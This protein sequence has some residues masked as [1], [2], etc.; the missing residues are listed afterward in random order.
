MFSSQHLY[1]KF[2]GD[3]AE[4]HRFIDELF[5]HRVRNTFSTIPFYREHLAA[6]GLTPDDFRGISDLPK[7]PV[8]DRFT[9]QS[10]DAEMFVSAAALAAGLPTPAYTS[11]TSGEPVKLYAS[12]DFYIASFH[13]MQLAYGGSAPFTASCLSEVDK[14]LPE[15][16]GCQVHFIARSNSVSQLYDRLREI[17][18]QVALL[19][20]RRWRKLVEQY[21]HGLAGLNLVVAG[22][23]GAA[24]T[25][26]ERAY[27]S[28]FVGCPVVDM[29]GATELGG[30]V[31]ECP[32]GREHVLAH[33]NY[34]EILD[35]D[36]RPTAPGEPGHLVW[37]AL[38][39]SIMP[40]IRYR[41][42]DTG[43]F[44]VDQEC[45]CDWNGPVVQGIGGKTREKIVFAGGMTVSAY[46]LNVAVHRTPG[47]PLF[48]D[49]RFRQEE[50][51]LISLS[52]VRSRF[53]G[54]EEF[55]G[56]LARIDRLLGG[57]IRIE[58]TWVDEIDQP[59][60]KPIHFVPLG[61]SPRGAAVGA[62]ASP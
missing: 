62:P 15:Q 54:E 47:P 36:D 16:D 12:R 32:Q 31:F 49:Y 52:A 35:D 59:I 3:A 9:I 24:S 29:Y 45:G 6:Q 26:E 41:I 53:F 25:P 22:S 51:D 33:H 13:L 2:T 8:A 40:F 21:G 34:L 55:R 37:T 1:R 19:G 42:G 7:L 50:F 46:R 39:N 17:G 11:G 18:P 28:T 27:L 56:L 5:S 20:P 61:R 23:A 30:A 57:H 14:A 44:A 38:D 48:D 43:E 60:D 58:T 10:R 4:Y